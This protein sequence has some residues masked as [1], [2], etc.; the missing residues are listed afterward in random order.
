MR[1]CIVFLEPCAMHMKVINLDACN[2]SI[3]CR[4]SGQGTGSPGLLL[5]ST[6]SLESKDVSLRKMRRKLREAL[7][8]QRCK[9]REYRNAYA[10]IIKR[11]S[12]MTRLSSDMKVLYIRGIFAREVGQ[13]LSICKL[14]GHQRDR[15]LAKS[16]APYG[17][18]DS[19]THCTG[20]M[21]K[22]ASLL[23]VR[24][25]ALK[26]MLERYALLKIVNTPMTDA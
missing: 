22:K 8:S 13:I 18:N 19:D 14:V 4:F 1:V 17:Y 23:R 10:L 16:C 3:A 2:L 11:N 7:Y 21:I 9:Q 5:I 20:D 26:F 25:T 24:D 6:W 12:C 15:R